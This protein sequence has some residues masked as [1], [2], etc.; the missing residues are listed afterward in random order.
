MANSNSNLGEGN[1]QGALLDDPE[2]LRDIVERVVQEFLEAEMQEH[3]GA[4]PYERNKE[5]RGQRNGYKPRMLRTRVGT[6]NLAIPQDREGT[7]STSIFARYQRN[8]KALVLSLMEMYVQGVSTR[9]VKEITEV[10]CGT[11][12]SKS[13]VSAL[14]G[15]LDAELSAWRRR[16]LSCRSYPII[17]V[18]AHYQDVRVGGRVVSQGVLI[19]KAIR[20]DGRREIIAIEVA[21]TESESAYNELFTDLKAR[22]LSGVLLV[23]SDAHQGLRKAA[24]RHFQGS[25]WQRCQ[26]HFTG[27]AMGLVKRAKRKEVAADLRKVFTADGKA[28]ARRLADEVM[29]KWQEANPKVTVLIDEHIEECFSS[30]DFPDSIRP[31]IRSTNGLERFHEEVRRRTRVVRI[32][33]N[34]ESC[35]RLISAICV[36]H[37]EEWVSGK[38]YVNPEELAES[39]PAQ[40]QKQRDLAVVT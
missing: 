23:V 18:D 22:G 21:D 7:F 19:V 11:S 40:E 30:F 39:E 3:I 12:F 33:P 9:K 24:K 32:F 17:F 16:P 13:Q 29:T 38:R 2:F 15:Q 28:Q 36:E 5:R 27:N 4:A 20:H 25:S 10:L 35:L 6:L 26:V 31:R 1:L 34:R 8:E 37:S 14:C